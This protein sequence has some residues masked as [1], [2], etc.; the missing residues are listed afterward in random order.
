M[1]LRLSDSRALHMM[2]AQR[3]KNEQATHIKSQAIHHSKMLQ[4]NLKEFHSFK[5]ELQKLSN[6]QEA[7]RAILA[8]DLCEPLTELRKRTIDNGAIMNSV[9]SRLQDLKNTPTLVSE[10]AVMQRKPIGEDNI[11]TSREEAMIQEL[12][13]IHQDLARLERTVQNNTYTQKVLDVP[14]LE[15]EG[16]REAFRDVLATTRPTPDLDLSPLISLG[17]KNIELTTDLDKKL[18]TIIQQE[19]TKATKPHKSSV[20][21]LREEVSILK[22]T[23]IEVNTPT[24]TALE[25]LRKELKSNVNSNVKSGPV[26]DEILKALYEYH[27]TQIQELQ[28]KEGV[29]NLISPKDLQYHKSY[30]PQTIPSTHEKEK[31]EPP[32]AKARQ[33]EHTRTFAEVLNRPRYPLIIESADPRHTSNDVA[34]KIKEK[35]DVV[36]LGVGVNGFRKMRHQKVLITCDT[37]NDRD[38][39]G[40]AIKNAGEK[41]TVTQPA[42][43]NPLIRLQGVAQDLNDKR[44]EEAVLKQNDRIVK[45]VHPEDRKVKVVRR[46]KGRIQNLN[47]VIVEVT[48]AL[49]N[50][51]RDQKLRIGYQIVSAIDQS[52]ILQCYRCLDFGHKARD[53]QSKGV[54]CGYC[55][56]NHDTRQCCNRN[57]APLCI[58]CNEGDRNHP[59]Y[60]PECP[61]WQKWDR[62]ARSTISYC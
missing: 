60:S 53:C 50:K 4:K 26:R 6:N 27:D 43:K 2:E 35:V 17:L 21:K 49:W 39:L 44:I 10:I 48:P 55:T 25:E 57:S 40:E 61:V 5:S 28:E 36:Q 12:R 15:P 41:L 51:L 59:A 29:C 42:T 1:V 13:M 20:D 11:Q 24:R 52:P 38:I 34:Q 14:T 3:A 45:G 54:C 23:M 22:D 9:S 46:V 56:E 7:I 32:L 31:Y 19:V 62:L 37:G 8:R 18:P 47:N 30:N 16:I 33:D 58:N